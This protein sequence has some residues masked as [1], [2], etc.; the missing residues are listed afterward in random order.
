MEVRVGEQQKLF[1]SVTAREIAEHLAEATRIDFEHRQIDLKQPIRELGTF[2]VPVKL[3]RNVIAHVTVNVVP[4]GG[5]VATEEAAVEE[6]PMIEGVTESGEPSMDEG[7]APIDDET[8][9][10]E[11]DSEEGAAD[12][13]SG[14]NESE[15]GS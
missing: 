11:A 14:E 8:A 12:E 4:I 7:S 6:E 1:G 13:A 2:S 15:E 10:R 3:T 5:P 9:T